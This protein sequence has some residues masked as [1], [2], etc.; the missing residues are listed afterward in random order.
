LAASALQFA[1]LPETGEEP[2]K[3]LLTHGLL[4]RSIPAQSEME[5]GRFFRKKTNNSKKM[6][7]N[8]FFCFLDRID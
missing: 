5:S 8:A 1:H 2:Q 3:L 6:Q 7:E 4:F